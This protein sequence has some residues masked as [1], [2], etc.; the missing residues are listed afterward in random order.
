MKWKLV[1]I[2]LYEKIERVD[3]R[4]F[5]HHFHFD[6][7]LLHLL[8]H[9]HPGEVIAERILLP[10][11]EVFGGLY[12]QGVGVNFGPAVRSGFQPDHMGP[13][14]DQ[15]IILVGGIVPDRYDNCHNS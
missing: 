8:L 2:L 15:V 14:V 10:V 13:H 1:C 6:S 11:D 3:D 12:V 7:K 4:H 9:H 5:C